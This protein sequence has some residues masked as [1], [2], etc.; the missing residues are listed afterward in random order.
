[1]RIPERA[2]GKTG[3]SV[4]V[5]GYGGAPVGFSAPKREMGFVPLI[6][7]AVDMGINFFDTAANYRRGEELFGLAIQGRR[8]KVVLATK[9]GRIQQ[10]RPGGWEDGEDWSEQGVLESI[11]RSLGKLRTD[12]I[13]LLQLH[14]PPRWVLEDGSAILG[15]QRA[16]AQGKI[17]HFGLSIDGPDA[18]FAVESGLFATLQVSMSILEQEP[19]D[20]IIPA[21]AER[22]MG[23]IIKQP[24]ANGVADMVERPIHSDWWPK[25]EAA[26][27]MD[28]EA[29]GAPHGRMQI[30]LRWLLAHPLVSTAIVGTT[31]LE[32]LEANM[33]AALLP[34]LD[35]A[36][37]ARARDEYLRARAS[38]GVEV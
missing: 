26:R 18:L 15:A 16:R 37:V 28:W 22:G 31:R 2:L 12:Y 6:Q 19:G 23:I 11:E 27:R 32:H 17:R 13:D 14:S 4:S 38:T 8:D 36:V 7:H 1:M 20:E 21:A 29:L 33:A 30:A 10:E 24:V 5:L 34:P 35:A 3:L 25:W 9:C